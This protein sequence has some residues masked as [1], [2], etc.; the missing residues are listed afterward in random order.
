MARTVAAALALAALVAVAA[1]GPGEVEVPKCEWA[2]EY[3]L[4]VA[5]RAYAWPK[6]PR[7]P[8]R[9]AAKDLETWARES[10]CAAQNTKEK[11][12]AAKKPNK[13]T[14]TD[15]CFWDAEQKFCRADV[16]PEL[17]VACEGDLAELTNHCS[18][19]NDQAPCEKD[20]LCIWEKVNKKEIC[21]PLRVNEL[22]IK[23][24][25]SYYIHYYFNPATFGTCDTSKEYRAFL[26]KCWGLKEGACKGSKI[27][28][29]W[30]NEGLCSV[31]EAADTAYV[32]TGDA[33]AVAAENYCAKISTKDACLKAGKAYFNPQVAKKYLEDNAPIPGLTAFNGN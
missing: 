20:D 1:A 10:L 25:P 30:P 21:Y 15:P 29:W 8:N 22:G 26:S 32:T 9:L 18:Q 17:D 27:C 12:D 28:K 19:F 5:T 4:C 13:L 16:D 7:T 33:A 23:T 31:S 14:T 2:S 3:W 24:V 11:C 6:S